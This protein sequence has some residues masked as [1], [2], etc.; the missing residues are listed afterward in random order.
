MSLAMGKSVTAPTARNGVP[1]ALLE[2]RVVTIDTIM[3]TVV[4]DGL[5][6]VAQICTAE[7]VA[8]CTAANIR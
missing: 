3:S 4:A 1:T 5:Y 7:Y 6:T 8:A 2:A